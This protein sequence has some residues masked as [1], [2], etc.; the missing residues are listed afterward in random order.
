MNFGVRLF[1][2]A[3]YAFAA[4]VSGVFSP[5]VSSSRCFSVSVKA[6]GFVM[7]TLLNSLAVCVGFVIDSLGPEVR[8]FP[9]TLSRHP[10]TEVVFFL[11][12]QFLCLKS[13]FLSKPSSGSSGGRGCLCLIPDSDGSAR[14]VSS[15]SGMLAMRLR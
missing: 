8:G 9:G 3:F 10:R 4:V 12:A 14:G 7:F 6:V 13:L 2:W 11:P 15:W 1:F 5:A